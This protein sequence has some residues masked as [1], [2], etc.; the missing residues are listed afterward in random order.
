MKKRKHPQSL[1]FQTIADVSFGGDKRDRTA[2][3]LNAIQALSQ[4]SY[5]PTGR[6]FVGCSV[7]IAQLPISGQ[8]LF[9]IFS[10]IFAAPGL[11]PFVPHKPLRISI[12]LRPPTGSPGCR[13]PPS[14]GFRPSDRSHFS[15][16]PST[17]TRHGLYWVATLHRPRASL[18]RLRRGL[19][20]ASL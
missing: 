5:T 15:S 14:R 19:T 13:T 8:A 9:T 6:P 10:L 20:L 4:L 18:S 3:L 1:Y 17:F 2:D 16:C 12:R 7:I 11:P